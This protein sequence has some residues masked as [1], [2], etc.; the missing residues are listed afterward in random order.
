MTKRRNDLCERLQQFRNRAETD[1]LQKSHMQAL[2]ESGRSLAELLASR[3]GWSFEPWD[4]VSDSGTE[5]SQ[6]ELL[7]FPGL[8]GSGKRRRHGELGNGGRRDT[9]TPGK[10][11]R[12]YPT[13]GSGKGASRR[14]TGELNR[15]SDNLHGTPPD[16]LTQ[17]IRRQ[18]PSKSSTAPATKRLSDRAAVFHHA[19]GRWP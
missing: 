6:M 16:L 10:P 18:T 4:G 13:W 11:A 15:I 1:E 2:F 19:E 17:S 14:S 3:G 12:K 8:F 5:E 7:V 9:D